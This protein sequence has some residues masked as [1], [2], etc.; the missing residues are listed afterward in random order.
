MKWQNQF[1]G[2]KVVEQ[3]T[4]LADWAQNEGGGLLCNEV[5]P[6]WRAI[7]IAEIMYYFAH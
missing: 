7:K 6:C 5:L 2:G 3:A 1:G 4:V